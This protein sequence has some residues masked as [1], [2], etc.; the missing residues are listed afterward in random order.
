MFFFALTGLFITSCNKNEDLMTSNVK[1]GGLVIPTTSIPYKL[2]N[3]PTADINL[4]VPQGS[5]IK[6]VEVYIEY[7]SYGD[8]TSSNKI[9]LETVSIGGSNESKDV[10]KTLAYT[11]TQMRN[12]LLVDGTPLPTDELLLDIGNYFTL[13]YIAVM[14]DDNRKVTNNAKTKISVANLYAGYYQ[15]DGVFNHPVNGPR[16]INE[17]KFLTPISAYTCNVSVGDLGASGYFVDITVN[18][19][20]NEVSFSNGTPVDILPTAG[21]T[22][23]FDPATGKFY[24]Y[25][26][27]V[28]STGNRVIEEEYTPL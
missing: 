13:S 10:K 6:S 12:G 23:Y 27:Y 16:T 19:A 5:P 26:Y 20:N 28:G 24:L 18:P 25:Y 7:Y 1:T 21:K 9:L 2:G 4:T 14:S 3:T 15:V 22:S 11:Y 17:E 8:D